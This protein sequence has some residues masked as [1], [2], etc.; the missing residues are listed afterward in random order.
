MSF[1]LLGILNSQATGGGAYTG[2]AFDHIQTVNTT[3][4]NVQFNN[5]DAL[6]D[7][8]HLQIRYS[9]RVGGGVNSVQLRMQMNNDTGSNYSRH[10]LYAYLAGLG[11]TSSSSINQTDIQLG[12]LTGTAQPSYIF[13]SGIVDILDFH[14]IDKTTNVQIMSTEMRGDL[15]NGDIRLSG[16]VYNSA[17]ALTS[18]KIFNTYTTFESGTTF[19]L[20]GRRG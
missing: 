16:G 9:G 2:P 3:G 17:N 1:M 7:Y 20:Y 6:E 14:S 15:S 12:D 18:I 4:N 8:K 19:A 10:W 11:I 13:S 5:L